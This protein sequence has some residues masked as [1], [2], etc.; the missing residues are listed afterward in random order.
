MTGVMQV[1]RGSSDDKPVVHITARRAII[2]VMLEVTLF[3]AF[4]SL[5][6][7]AIPNVSGHTEDMLR[8]M[9]DYFVGPWFGGLV[10]IVFS[11]L[12]LSAANTAIIGL[13]SILYLMSHDGE[14]PS[15]F[16][17]LNS[18]GVPRIPL[19]VAIAIP[20][21]VLLIET[22]VTRLAALYAI[23]VVG[24]ITIHLGAC[25]TNFKLGLTRLER[26]V[27]MGTFV[28]MGLIELSIA[29]EKTH[30]L[31]FAII[32]LG[33]GLVTRSVGRTL[34]SRQGHLAP[35][36]AHHVDPRGRPRAHRHAQV[37]RR[38]SPS[39]RCHPICPVCPGDC[40]ARERWGIP[41]R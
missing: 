32:I 18:Y 26:S 11:L 12:L 19:I 21:I 5:A 34:Q 24:A 3:T 22:D 31:L 38:P 35:T 9:G 1:D 4:L 8:Y 30:A 37:R 13:V 15:S 23:G 16:R 17:R 7:H 39:A 10:G 36:P 33:I 25:A 27:M 6:L 40:I 41:G 20:V 14:M 29:Y 2:P 28:M